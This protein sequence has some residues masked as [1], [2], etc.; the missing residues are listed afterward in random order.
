MIQALALALLAAVEPLSLIGFI[1][2]LGSRGGRRNTRAF[3]IGWLLCASA[4]ALVTVLIAGGGHAAHASEAVA[5]AAMVQL[6]AGLGVLG[7]FVLRRRRRRTPRAHEAP[8]WL[9]KVDDLRPAGAATTG[10]LV[11]G[12]PIVAA[13][14]GAVLRSVNSAA[15]R[16]AGIAAVIIVCTSTF[17]TAHVLAGRAPERTAARLAA[18]RAWIEAHQERVVDLLLLAVSAYLVVHGVLAVLSA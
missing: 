18:L 8:R 17:L 1:A 12:W 14:V 11:Q 9:A 10:A 15:G 2:V 6:A 5:S 3:I 7:L 4:I 13:A 16:A